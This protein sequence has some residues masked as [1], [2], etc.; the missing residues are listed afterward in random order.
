MISSDLVPFA[1]Q[2]VPEEA[3]IVPAGDE[4]GFAEA[5]LRLL[6]DDDDRRQRAARAAEK[7]KALDWKAQTS[8]FIEFLSRR[9]V[10]VIEGG[11][12]Q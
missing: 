9:G 6:Q 3:L 4:E 7:V 10:A 11:A 1:V 8:A 2:Y 5:M 12:K